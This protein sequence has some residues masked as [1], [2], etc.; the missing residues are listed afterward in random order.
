VA[1]YRGRDEIVNLL[2]TIGTVIEDVR[3]RR[4]LRP[5]EALLEGVKRMRTTLGLETT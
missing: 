5:L 4:E 3:V 1:D 2:A